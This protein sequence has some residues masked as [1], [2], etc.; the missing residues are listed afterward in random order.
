MRRG[1]VDVAVLAT[2]AVVAF[3][4]VV[5]FNQ[6]GTQ[7]P[8]DAILPIALFSV[9]VGG[10]LTL[11]A[12][13]LGA[14]AQRGDGDAPAVHEGPTDDGADATAGSLDPPTLDQGFAAFGTGLLALA[15]V[16]WRWGVTVQA[17]IVA[18][19]G[20]ALLLTAERGIVLTARQATGRPAPYR[21]CL[22]AAE[23]VLLVGFAWAALA[24]AGI[25]P[26]T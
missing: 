23:A 15:A 14:V 22:V 9:G 4:V 1:V 10:L 25:R 18:A 24:D 3:G 8:V 11:T 16:G 7:S 12:A 21:L 13:L 5:G 2:D 26:F 19:Q 17:A 6:L 20:L